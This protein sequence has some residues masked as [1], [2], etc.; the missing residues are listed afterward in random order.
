M[1]GKPRGAWS[2]ALYDCGNSAFILSVVTTLY[3][4]FFQNVWAQGEPDAFQWL[5]RITTATS[6]VVA[7]IAVAAGIA[8]NR[9]RRRKRLLAT[10][11]GIGILATASLAIISSGA[12][13]LAAVARL[14][15]SIGFFGSLVFYDALLPEVSTTKNQHRISALGFSVGYAGS[16]LLLIGQFALIQNPGLLGLSDAGAATRLSF[17]TAAIWWLLFTLP[18]LFR[19][20]ESELPNPPGSGLREL[21]GLAREI[22][23]HRAVLLFL[24]AYWFYIDGVNTFAQMASAFATELE[25]PMGELMSAIILVQIVGVPCALILGALGQ[26]FGPRPFIVLG[27]IVYLGVTMF[28]YRLSTEPIEIF[29]FAVSQMMLLG[30]GIG[31]VQG[32]LQALSRS[33]YNSLIPADRASA[34]FGAYNMLGKG[35]AIL[36]PLLMGEIAAATGDARN[37]ALAV[38]VL[39]LIGLTLFLILPRLAHSSGSQ[40]TA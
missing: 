29:G 30:I 2:W 14:V 10:F 26:R 9:G 22:C 5:A 39:F 20:S 33:Y 19:V 6:I 23:Q 3:A 1:E 25:I 11:A 4:P 35:G 17:L 37:G 13:E 7:V 40:S 32:G 16:V 24:L 12:W 31:A 15:A 18:L 28:A 8:G 27:I 34:F 36:G 38:G 21:A